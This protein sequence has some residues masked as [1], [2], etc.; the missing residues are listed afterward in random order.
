MKTTELKGE[1]IGDGVYAEHNGY[2]IWLRTERLSAPGV[3]ITH[4]IYLEPALLMR[5]QEIQLAGRSQNISE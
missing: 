3:V 5:L 2:G 4:E 1:Y